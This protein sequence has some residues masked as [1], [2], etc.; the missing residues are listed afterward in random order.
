MTTT[1][2]VSLQSLPAAARDVLEQIE[3]EDRADWALLRL[4]LCAAVATVTLAL[5]GALQL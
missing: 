5:A 4:V 1:P 3:R 2:I